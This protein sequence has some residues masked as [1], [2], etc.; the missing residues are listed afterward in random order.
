MKDKVRR[1]RRVRLIDY[2]QHLKDME[3]AL[4]YLFAPARSGRGREK[5]R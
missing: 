4:L 5:C 2:E 3:N 1:T